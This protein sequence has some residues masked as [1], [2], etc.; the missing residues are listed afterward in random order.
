MLK[1]MVKW[2]LQHGARET[3]RFENIEIHEKL[4]KVW[5]E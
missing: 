4:P 2:V 1:K 5:V 3:P